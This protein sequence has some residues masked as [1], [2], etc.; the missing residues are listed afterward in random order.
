MQN[1]R[2]KIVPILEKYKVKE[3]SL[4]GSYARGDA[5]EHSDIDIVIR[6]PKGM[7]IGFIELKIALE[8]SLNKKVDLVSFNG[9]NKYLKPFILENQ[10]PLL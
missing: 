4:F 9:I 1:I 2:N 7:G 6:P 5:D 8:D 10:Q 3:A